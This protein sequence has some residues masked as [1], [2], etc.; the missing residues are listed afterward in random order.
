MARDFGITDKDILNAVNYHTTGR[1]GMSLLEKIIY[2]A[3]LIEPGR[4]YTGVEDIREMALKDL[5]KA[6][7]ASLEQSISFV[8]EK[9]YDLDNDTVEAKNDIIKKIKEDLNGK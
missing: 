9:G 3:D 4:N 8:R 7:L 6:L 2:I 5:D 1:K